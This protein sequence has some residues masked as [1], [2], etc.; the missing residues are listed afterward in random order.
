[1]DI[2]FN[3][4]NNEKMDLNEVSIFVKVIQKGSFTAAAQ[5]LAMPKSTV[6]TKIT[7]LEKRLGV[8]LLNRST[9]RLRLTTAGEAFFLRS[10]KGLD[11]IAAAEQ[12]MRSENLE[13]Q[14]KF[15]ITAPVDLGNFILPELTIPFLKKYPKVQLDIILTD[16][17][18]DFL[19]E[20]IDLAI[21][22]GKLKD[23]SLIAKKLGEGAFRIFASP[24]FLRETGRPKNIT[25]ILPNQCVLVKSVTPD[26]WNL[27]N[28]KKTFQISSAGSISVNDISLARRFA[29]Q[30]AGY[31]LLPTFLCHDDVKAGK[32]EPV[33]PEWR[34]NINPIHFVYPAQ[35]YV[36]PT[37]KAF[38]EMSAPVLQKHFKMFEEL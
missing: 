3:T 31:A 36:T 19:N 8:T 27:H 4:V 12:A 17:Y 38:I 32:L 14:G 6:S 16:R 15:R 1:M 18:V 34:T 5:A 24:K 9:R 25:A 28:G 33:L 10:A 7:A 21:R 35:K 20:E 26:G 22:G 37:T 13:P 2:L 30:G 29:I 11:E 23:S